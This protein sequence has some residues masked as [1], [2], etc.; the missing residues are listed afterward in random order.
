MD[1]FSRQAWQVPPGLKN[2]PPDQ[3]GDLSGLPAGARAVEVYRRLLC[4]GPRP[5]SAVRA[6]LIAEGLSPDSGTDRRARRAL[7]VVS[8]PDGWQGEHVLSLPEEPF[9]AL[10][11]GRV[12][13]RSRPGDTEKDHRRRHRAEVQEARAV[14]AARARVTGIQIGGVR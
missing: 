13:T 8:R 14:L 9:L 1:T 4:S 5:I 7:G 2:A 11:D 10:R 12:L 3:E 6:A